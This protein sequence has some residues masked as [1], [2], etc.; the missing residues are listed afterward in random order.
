MKDLGVMVTDYESV[1]S[2]LSKGPKT[3]M[4]IVAE[5][6]PEVNGKDLFAAI[7]IISKT[8]FRGSR[9]GK[10]RIVKTIV[11]ERGKEVGVWEMVE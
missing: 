2:S 9:T 1:I 6:Y 3:V 7:H 8:L 11:D 5:H 4:E 10:F